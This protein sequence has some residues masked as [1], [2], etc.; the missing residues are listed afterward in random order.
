MKEVNVCANTCFNSLF[1][2]PQAVVESQSV[3]Q[4]ESVA[5]RKRRLLLQ[6][7]V[8]VKSDVE[9]FVRVASFRQIFNGLLVLSAE[10]DV[11]RL[12]DSLERSWIARQGRAPSDCSRRKQVG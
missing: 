2:A 4:E 10:E 8:A 7:A 9:R 6:N 3:A 11:L 12:K 1:Q 5:D